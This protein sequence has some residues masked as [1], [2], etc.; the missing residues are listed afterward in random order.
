MSLKTWWRDIREAAAYL[1][2]E[3]GL[4]GLYEYMAVTNGMAMGYSPPCSWVT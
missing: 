3:H 2:Q 4:H 1:R